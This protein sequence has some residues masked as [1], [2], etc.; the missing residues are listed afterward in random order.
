VRWTLETDAPAVVIEI[1]PVAGGPINRL[2]LAPNATPHDLFIS[3]LP[4]EDVHANTH[5]ELSEEEL[6]ALHFGAYYAL[7][8][9]EPAE[10]PMPRLWRGPGEREATGNVGTTICPPGRFNP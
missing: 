3:N 9:H 6:A 4:A 5:H 2:V 7:L 10:R 8:L 1:V